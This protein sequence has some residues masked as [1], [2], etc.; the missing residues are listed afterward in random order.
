MILIKY[1]PVKE[2]Y[3]SIVGAVPQDVKFGVRVQINSCIAPS[4]VFMRIYNDCGYDSEVQM[5]SDRCE[6]GF[7]NF[8]V[9]SPKADKL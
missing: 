5:Y 8:R 7:Y 1:N 4:K 2:F 9:F 6:E 3:K